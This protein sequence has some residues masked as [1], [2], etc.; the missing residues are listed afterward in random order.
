MPTC[1]VQTQTLKP[2]RPLSGIEILMSCMHGEMRGTAQATQ[3]LDIDGT[4]DAVSLVQSAHDLFNEF[5]VLAGCIRESEGQ[6][7]FYVGVDFSSIPIKFEQASDPQLEADLLSSIVDTPLPQEKFLW[8][9]TIFTGNRTRNYRVAM[10]FHHA[11]LDG[12]GLSVVGTRFLHYLDNRINKEEITVTPR[13]FPQAI[14]DFLTPKKDIPISTAKKSLAHYVNASINNRQTK[15]K[16]LVLDSQVRERL[17]NRTKADRLK[18]NA[19][20]AAA[21][22]K[23]LVDTKLYESPVE[24]KNAVSL[25]IFEGTQDQKSSNLGCYMSVSNTLLDTNGRE[26]AEIAKGYEVGLLKDTLKRSLAKIQYSFADV[27]AHILRNLEND[28]FIG[29]A[30]ITNIGDI[31][32]PTHYRS[33]VLSDYFTTVNRTGGNYAVVVH[34]YSFNNRLMVQFVYP[35]PI[36][37]EKKIND[38]VSAFYT[39]LELYMAGTN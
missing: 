24:L 39:N 19:I 21:L 5:P 33:F 37:S 27:T 8:K 29:G 10:T 35:A 2:V 18:I 32:I 14:N 1:E 23:S 20:F 25:R 38:L 7:Y 31:S 3:V 15:W 16:T 4:L 26:V 6:I 30:G 17:E 13:E 36:M 34:C 28:T 11:I 22:G 9:M 12:H